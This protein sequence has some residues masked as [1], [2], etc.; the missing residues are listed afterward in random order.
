M[1]HTLVEL[2]HSSCNGEEGISHF[3][4][5]RNMWLEK[6]IQWHKN[7]GISNLY[8]NYKT[9]PSKTIRNLQR[10]CAQTINCLPIV[11]YSFSSSDIL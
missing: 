3:M 2:T 5:N 7:H 4:L 8:K 6:K 9:K 10:T 11:E 1:G